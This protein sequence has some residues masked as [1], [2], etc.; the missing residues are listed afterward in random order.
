[1][2]VKF[3][4][5]QKLC[6]PDG[7]AKLMKDILSLEGEFDREKEHFWVIGL[8]TLNAIKY[9][10]L[11]SIGIINSCPTHAREV[12]RFAVL[13]GVSSIIIAHNHPGGSIRPSTD[14]ERTT[15]YL[16]DSGN[17]LNITVLDS[18]IIAEEGYY[19]FKENNRI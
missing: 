14:D 13:K 7:V 12:F 15:K 17:I 9:I 19:S 2:L 6:A 3:D 18:I 16:V 1:M 10:D 8:N 5:K 4:C 11:V